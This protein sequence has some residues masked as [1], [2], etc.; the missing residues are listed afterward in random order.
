MRHLFSIEPVETIM[1]THLVCIDSKATVVEAAEQMS[2][3]QISSLLVG[4]ER[5]IEGILCERDIVWKVLAN[6]LDPEQTKVSKIMSTPIK[7]IYAHTPICEVYQ[8]MSEENIR[9]LLVTKSAK[10]VGIISVHDLIYVIA[11]ETEEI[12]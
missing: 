2:K 1:T 9:H 11:K 3:Q 6:G 8:K 12:R 10:V 5:K 7:S 4:D